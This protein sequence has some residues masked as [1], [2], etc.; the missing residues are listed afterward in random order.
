[1]VKK[2]IKEVY[3]FIDSQNLNLGVSKDIYRHGKLIYKGWK[4]DFRKFRQYLSDKFRVTKAFLFIGYLNENKSLY[5][6]LESCNFILIFKTTTKDHKG[7]P[8]GNVD[9]ELVLY[10]A[11]IEYPHFDSAV[12]V[13]GDGDFLCLYKFLKRKRKLKGIV[14]PNR[15]SESSLLK[16]FQ[17]YKFFLNREQNKL[18]FMPKKMGG[19][20]L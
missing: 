3:V 6:Y 13:S 14:I 12:I 9:A 8:K 2:V 4:L 1:M 11:A 18:E 10:A 7:K 15:Y 19:V 5:T 16:E 20:A 17:E